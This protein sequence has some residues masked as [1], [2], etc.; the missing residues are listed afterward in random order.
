MISLARAFERLGEGRLAFVGDG[1]LRDALEGRHGVRVVGR[2][3]ARRRSPRGSRPRDVVCQPSLIEPFG[4]ALLEAMASERSVVATRVGGPPEFVTAEAG[5]LVDPDDERSIE[6]GSAA[7]AELPDPEPGRPRGRRAA[8]RQ[9]CRRSRWRR[10]SSEPLE[11]GEP[12]LDERAHALLQPGLPRDRERLL[13]ALARLRGG[14][15]LLEPVVAGHQQL[16]NACR[17]RPAAS[18]TVT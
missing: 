7:A 6:A 13:V 18:T 8:R 10:S 9:A 15:A 17:E 1:P 4:Q 16:L 3:A 2:V 14:D 12:E 11:V 5:V